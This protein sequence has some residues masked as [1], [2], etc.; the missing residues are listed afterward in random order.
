[1]GDQVLYEFFL[2]DEGWGLLG[3]EG[4]LLGFVRGGGSSVL[5]EGF[6]SSLCVGRQVFARRASVFLCVVSAL[7]EG[8]VVCW[9]CGSLCVGCQLFA[10]L[11]KVIAWGRLSTV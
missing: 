3:G 11:T 1:M 2:G 8:A 10:G 5:C 4:L 9:G 7:C 6:V